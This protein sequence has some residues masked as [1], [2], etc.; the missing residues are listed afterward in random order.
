MVISEMEIRLRADIASL[1]RDMN[2]A[3]QT[4]TSATSGMARAADAA[5]SALAGIGLGL[6]IAQ[7]I[8]MTDQYTKFTAQLRLATLSTREY[9]QAMASVKAISTTAQASIADIGVLYAKIANGTRELGNSQKKIAEITEVVG[10]GLKVSGATAQEASSAMLQL[11]QAFASG[12]LRGEEFNAVNEAGP[13]VMLALAEGIGVPV[14]ALKKMAEEGKLTSDVLSEAL[15]R[16]LQKLR[17]EAKEVQT[18][19]GAFQVLKDRVM[20]VSAVRAKDNGSVAAMTQGI[21]LLADNLTGLLTVMTGLTVIKGGTWAAEWVAG[22]YARIAANKQLT[23]SAVESASVEMRRAEAE[24]QSALIAQSRAREGVAAARAEVAADRQRM[25]SAAAT[26]EAA[27]AARLAQ[28]TETGAIVRAEIALEK[29]RLAAQINAIGR[30]ARVAEMARLATQLDAIQ[31][32]MAASSAE[33]AAVRV[34]NE[35]AAAAAA[36]AGAAKIAAAREA[37]VIATGGAAAATLR[38]RL[39]SAGLTAAMG[40]ASVA[41]NIL[42]GGLALLGGPVGAV[43]TLLTVGGMAWMTWGNKAEEAND[44]VA[45][46]TEE[47]TKEMIARL[48]KQIE[49]LRERNNLAA[50][51]PR[52]KS[53]GELNDADA[54]GLA[55]A[56]AA[57]E[58]NRAQQAALPNGREKTL[59]QLSEIDLIYDYD[60]A[61]QRVNEREKE[62]A[63]GKDIAFNKRYAEWLGQNGTAEEK[64]R[65]ELEKLRQEYGRVTPAMIAWVKAKYA[66]KGAASQIKQ[67]QTAYQNLVTSVQE[68]IA[69]NELELSGYDKLTES[70]KMTIKLDAA[71]GTGKNKLS[72]EHINEARALI[73]KVAAQ[74]QAIEAQQRSAQWA[75]VEAK[76][77]ADHYASLRAGTAA[78]DDRIKQMERE[79]ETYGLSASAAIDMERAKLQAK[80]DA[81]PATYAELIALDEQIAKLTKLGELTRKKEGLEANVD[82]TQAKELLDIMSAIDESARSAAQGMADSFGRV[83]KAIGGLTTALSGLGK[84]QAAI[85]AQLAAATKAAAGDPAKVAAATTLAARQS[86]QAQIQSYGDMAAAGKDFFDENSRGY[87][88][89]EAAE[90]TFRAFEVALSI[91]TMLEKSGILT[92]F[93]AMF[94]S[95]KATETAATVASVGPDVAA[96]MVKGQAAAAAGVAGQAQG[97]PYS[98]WARMAAMAAVMAGLGFAIGGI[99]G[100]KDTTAAD[101]QKATGTGSVLGDSAAKSESIAKA[102]ELSAANSNIELNYTAGMLRSLR[103]IESSITGLGGILA[104]NGVTGVA[105]AS[106]YGSAGSTLSKLS[107]A[108]D[109]LFA[110]GL[111]TVTDKLLGGFL[112]KTIG[113]I[114]NA[115]FGGK[116]EA[117]DVGVMANKTTVAGVYAG[118]W[119][120]QS[121]ADMKKSGGWFHSDDYWTDPKDLGREADQQFSQI[122]KN[123]SDAVGEAGKLLGLGS[124]AFTQRLNS[125]VV[126]IGKIS[127]KD[128]SADEIQKQLEAAFSKVG[129]D[130]ARWA[131][132]GLTDFQQAGEGALETLVRI[133]ANYA[134]LDSVLAS[135]GK[136]FGLVGMSSISVR[137]EFID[138]A[139]GIDELASKTA[140]FAE[141]FLTEAERLAPVQKYVTDQLSA[142]GLAGLRSRE[143]FK[144]YVLGLDLTSEAQRQQYVALMDLQEAFAKVYPEIVDTTISLADAKTALADAY[145]AEVDAIGATIDRMSSFASSLRSLRSSAVLGNLSPL[146]PQQKY[147]EAKAQYEAVLSAAR[148]GDEAAQSNYQ[149]AFTSFLEASRTVFASS[150]QYQQDFY[151]AQAATEEAARWAEAQVDVGQA[152]LTALEQQVSGLIEVKQ[153]VMSVREAILQLN[154]VMGKNTAPLTAVAPPVNTPIP[155]S[156]YGTSNT[157]ALVAEVKALRTEVSGLRAD[158]NRQT[159]DIIRGGAA[160][161]ESS[162]AMIAKATTSAVK[163]NL[164]QDRVAPE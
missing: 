162:A 102:I 8:E 101:R 47:A 60:T 130:M 160:A 11:S 124:T 86:A 5:K 114:G 132:G 158:A 157:E 72:E 66:D 120:A 39:A 88:A 105:P 129:D 141:N 94:V 36:A 61:L 87:K 95:S 37:E 40:A 152:Q 163:S 76:N 161:S 137:E 90:K 84:N 56:K 25:A 145:N 63:R 113:K 31:K 146:S 109:V 6:G 17:E 70:Q 28:F 142:M 75:E 57:L 104:Q 48:D 29:T 22:A 96:S 147:A 89:M 79:I 34:A 43:I 151:Y 67:E 139:G 143:S 45:Q 15:P 38:L 52:I 55:S 97:D 7:V 49:K 140:S 68:K 150:D 77:D 136:S 10:L 92:A 62:L 126:D 99:G 2:A 131:V 144:Q 14:G 83:G 64:E 69:A 154:A 78:I 108:A 155:Y 164:T 106:T 30:T 159:G 42:R 82:V 16:S 156:S 107:T 135:V 12:V 127:T 33:L 20:E 54:A 9:T 81:G 1:Q 50:T 44:K 3:R 23:A 119:R 134:N 117:R 125:F 19:S 93:T 74:E 118:Q 116:T 111:A 98:A 46:S 100:G 65:Y 153:E 133:A 41:G 128:L 32:G 24:R 85:A 122:I 21:A 123:M 112:S 51:E 149:A 148:G 58:A 121:Y 53:L 13:R 18:I 91:K 103:A 59:L 73:D 35:N 71:I 110:G 27:V 4:V 80:L 26:A 115:I 138:L